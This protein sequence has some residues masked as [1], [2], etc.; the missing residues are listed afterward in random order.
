[1]YTYTYIDAYINLYMCLPQDQL[2]AIVEAVQKAPNT[3]NATCDA[4]Q[5][6][7]TLKSPIESRTVHRPQAAIRTKRAPG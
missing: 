4:S 7:W 6:V 2:Q 3:R 5:K 1:M